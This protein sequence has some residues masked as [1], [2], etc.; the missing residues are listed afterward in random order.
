MDR[1]DPL[2]NNKCLNVCL[3][4]PL[5]KRQITSVERRRTWT[6]AA[7]PQ[8]HRPEYAHRKKTCKTRQDQSGAAPKT[9]TWAPINF[10]AKFRSPR[11]VFL[12]QNIGTPHPYPN[13]FLDMFTLSVYRLIHHKKRTNRRVWSARADI[14]RRIVHDTLN[15]SQLF[16][17][18]A[19]QGSSKL[20][21]L[22][23]S[24]YHEKQTKCR[25][26]NAWTDNFHR[27]ANNS[28]KKYS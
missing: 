27:A 4:E 21:P 15:Y 12:W 28:L 3:H 10:P 5:R 14:S 25:D 24:T 18:R 6:E 20:L 1:D 11:N 16:G 23:T 17:H 2:N 22:E 9:I 13:M 19:V 7:H 8:N 26:W